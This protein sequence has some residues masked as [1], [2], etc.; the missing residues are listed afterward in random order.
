MSHKL[1]IS[2][3]W[4][5]DFKLRI[6]SHASRSA[7]STNCRTD[8]VKCS[9]L[10]CRQIRRHTRFVSHVQN[11]TDI[12]N[13]KCWEISDVFGICT[14]R[15]FEVHLQTWLTIADFRNVVTESDNANQ[16]RWTLCFRTK[17][18]T[19]EIPMIE[20]QSNTQHTINVFIATP[21][22]TAPLAVVVLLDP[23]SVR[24]LP[25]PEVPEFPAA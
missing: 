13:W 23:E 19:D 1:G 24:R 9:Q 21:K 16:R 14:S 4:L 7:N 11:R 10:F 3:R 25:P 22:L 18:L 2:T 8:L 6:V 15:I 20:V 12:D 5:R 17:L